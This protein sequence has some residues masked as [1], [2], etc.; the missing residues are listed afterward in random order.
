MITEGCWFIA[1]PV[2]CDFT[3]IRTALGLVNAN[4]HKTPENARQTPPQAR[5][6]KPPPKPQPLPSGENVTQYFYTTADGAMVF[7]VIRRDYA[8]KPK[9][10]SQWMPAADGQWLP[11]APTER[12]PMYQ[13]PT[14]GA[15][16]TVA[17]VEGEK[18]VHA[19]REAWPKQV[20][21][22]W[23]GGANAWNQTDWT[24]LAGRTVSLLADG[25]DPGH[26]A[27]QALALH[28][29][30]LGVGVKIALPPVEWDSDVA[31]W[32]AEGG[33][34]AAAKTIAGLLADYEPPADAPA[35]DAEPAEPLDLLIETGLEEI[36]DNPHYRLLGLVGTSVAVRLREAGVVFESTRKSFTE[37]STLVGIAPQTWW[38]G[39]AGIDKLTTD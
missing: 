6:P 29:H 37:R 7:A 11:V 39:W 23:A 34:A 9:R 15:S 20:T 38:C 1:L 10:F 16:G 22:C 12:K 2:P 31:D 35:P 26:K 4:G 19:C 3:A 13:L 25:D 14:V 28:L 21:V 27:M 8:D 36:R 24:P 17:I 30:S 18:C 33:K 32:I 5:Q